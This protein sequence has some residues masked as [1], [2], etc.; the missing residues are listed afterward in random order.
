MEYLISEEY[1][2]QITEYHNSRPWGGAVRGNSMMLNK[3]M[4]ISG[5]K[6]ILDYGAGRSD[7]LKE[8]NAQ[9]PNRQYIINEYEP[10]R[11][12]LAGDPPASD[13]VVSFDVMEHIEPNKVDNVIKHIYEKCNMWTYH[14]ICLRA[15]TGAFPGT[16]QNLHLTIKDG[17]WWLEKFSKYFIFLETLMNTGYVHFLAIPKK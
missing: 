8:M 12:E 1:K 17:P 6:T 13:A 4:M 5:A 16:E 10:G 7:L 15:A 2:K 3:Y 14:K 11:P 9:Y